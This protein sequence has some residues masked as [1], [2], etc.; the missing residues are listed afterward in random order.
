MKTEKCRDCKEDFPVDEIVTIEYKKKK[1]GICI[2]CWNK[3]Y[4]P[5]T[6]VIS[7]LLDAISNLQKKKEE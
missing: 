4:S 5:F 3:Y 2:Y 6:S 1:V 7:T